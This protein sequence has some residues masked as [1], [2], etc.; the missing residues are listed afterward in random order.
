MPTTGRRWLLAFPLALGL[1]LGVLPLA[2]A[3][4]DSSLEDGARSALAAAGVTGVTVTSDWAG[5]RLSGPAGSR[6]AALAAVGRMDHRDAVAR[7]EYALPAAVPAPSVPASPSL[8]SSPSVIPAPQP[9]VD[10]AVALRISGTGTKRALRLEGTVAG[11]S[12]H[13]ALVAAVSVWAP[14]ARLD[15]ATTVVAG[16]PAAAVAA[17]WPAYLRIAGRAAASLTDKGRVALGPDGITLSGLTGKES[18]A[19]A[20]A[21]LAE[22]AGARGIPVDSTVVGPVTATRQKLS[23]VKGLAGVKFTGGSEVLTAAS[24]RSLNNAARII[25]A[26]PAGVTVEIRGFTDNRGDAG[27]N[28]RLSKR[29]ADEVRKYLISKGVPPKRLSAKG[30][31]EKSP[32]ASNATDK[33]RAAN[34]RIEFVVKGS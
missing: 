34:R 26:M 2:K 3:S 22:E 29:R 23:K 4:V 30:F 12:A 16:E 1:G 28:A 21:G 33:G 5:L 32:R 18:A 11:E 20:L 31:G 17:A 15:D 8:S 19:A 7:V 6:D 14:K 9:P 10:V 25:R 27:L 24:K 13:E